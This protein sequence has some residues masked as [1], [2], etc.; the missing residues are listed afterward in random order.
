M[1]IFLK[2][3]IRFVLLKME[4]KKYCVLI[5]NYKPYIF[6][7]IKI[8]E[9]MVTYTTLTFVNNTLFNL[10]CVKCKNRHVLHLTQSYI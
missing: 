4:M 5:A 9:C 7:K 8:M 2:F 1:T 3:V 6:V 10:N